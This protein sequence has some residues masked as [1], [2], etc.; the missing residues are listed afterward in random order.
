MRKFLVFTLFVL[1]VLIAFQGCSTIED[2]PPATNEP[3]VEINREGHI[4]PDQFNYDEITRKMISAFFDSLVEVEFKDFEKFCPEFKDFNL[5]QKKEFFVALFSFMSKYESNFDT[6]ATF[7]EPFRD[8]SGERVVSSGLL[9]VSIESCRGYGTSLDNKEELLE[10]ERNLECSVR[11]MN[12]WSKRDNYIA[13]KINGRWRGGARY[14]A[15]LRDG[16][17]GHDEIVNLSREYCRADD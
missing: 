10:P 3:V 15:V 7:R 2:N 5:D 16:N 6:N 9:Q 17:R 11:I 4:W 1:L 12:R 14:W 8:R 13:S